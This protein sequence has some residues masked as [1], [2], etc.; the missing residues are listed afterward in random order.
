MANLSPIQFQ[1]TATTTGSEFSAPVQEENSGVFLGELKDALGLQGDAN[2]AEKRADE[3]DEN[4][5]QDLNVE[6]LGLQI[7][8]ET[9]LQVMPVAANFATSDASTLAPAETDIQVMVT[10]T[11]MRSALVSLESSN[12][13]IPS[14]GQAQ[15]PAVLQVEAESLFTSSAGVTQ[16][17]NEK[18]KV[19]NVSISNPIPVVV[20]PAS[21][22]VALA[23][24]AIVIPTEVVSET[25]LS[26]NPVRSDAIS[27]LPTPI[28]LDDAENSVMPVADLP[29]SLKDAGAID[30]APLANVA[31]PTAPLLIGERSQNIV[32]PALVVTSG[33]SES[34][35]GVP[36]QS[37]AIDPVNVLEASDSPV[38]VAIASQ[39]EASYAAADKPVDL[40]VSTDGVSEKARSDVVTKGQIVV[41][42]AEQLM[43]PVSG[44]VASDSVPDTPAHPIAK[45]SEWGSTVAVASPPA[46]MD[47]K[48]PATQKNETASLTSVRPSATLQTVGTDQRD[49]PRPTNATISELDPLPKQ[50]AF[51]SE[52]GN[53]KELLPA[54]IDQSQAQTSFTSTLLGQF[55]SQHTQPAAHQIFKPTSVPAPL[56]PHQVQLDAGEVKVEIMRLVKQGG[57][58]IVMEL[59]PP[60]QSKFRIDLKIDA[61]GVASLV[62][63]GASDSTR[64]RLERGAEGLQ[65]QFADMG[66][67]L[68]LDMRQSH[69]PGAQREAMQQMQSSFNPSGALTRSTASSVAVPQRSRSVGEGQVHIY[70]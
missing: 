57:G 49:L 36:L 69:D 38:Q 56:E 3:K 46:D 40:P 22:E 55:T 18:D 6:F 63:E 43:V 28:R 70:A 66:L 47:D 50:V 7:L 2:A 61:Q 15:P 5:P 16:N 35:S 34:E 17:F 19:D 30:I 62:V 48:L 32:P 41:P 31:V 45:P 59:T 33:T 53:K 23:T 60:D 20:A 14:S 64:S 27:S 42:T 51:Q 12:F 13:Q 1:A 11:D 10:A 65:Q 21:A 4:S 8:P 52:V 39:E 58:Q 44:D 25:T 29:T 24:G 54:E 68:Q 9:A 67:A 26:Q 37:R